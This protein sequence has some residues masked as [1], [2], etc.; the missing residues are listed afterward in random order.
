ML[1]TIVIVIIIIILLV[2]VVV[3]VVVV[4]L[5]PFENNLLCSLH[6]VHEMDAYRVGHVCLFA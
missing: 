2:V 6:D 5:F 1:Q 3:V 4:L